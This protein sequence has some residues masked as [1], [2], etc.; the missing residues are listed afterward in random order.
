MPQTPGAYPAFISAEEH[1]I[2][3]AMAIP[4]EQI[5]FLPILSAKDGH[6]HAS[7]YLSPSIACHESSLA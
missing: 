5:S 1:G 2:S 7:E 3:A 4:N 6:F